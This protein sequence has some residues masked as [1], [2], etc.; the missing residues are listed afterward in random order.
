MSGFDLLLLG[1]VLSNDA[2]VHTPRFACS[3]TSSKE[4]MG[5]FSVY[6]LVSL[7][8]ESGLT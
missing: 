4:E 8:V 7:K 5:F 2:D 6:L 1:H 3:I